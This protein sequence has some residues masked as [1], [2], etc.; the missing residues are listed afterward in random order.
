MLIVQRFHSQVY[1]NELLQ[2]VNKIH[3]PH[4]NIYLPEL[5]EWS[6]PWSHH[7]VTEVH[8]SVQRQAKNVCLS[9]F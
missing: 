6:A 9:F 8:C 3:H 1:F 4:S 5:H 2:V 7:G